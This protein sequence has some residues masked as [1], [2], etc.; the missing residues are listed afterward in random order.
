MSTNQF[1]HFSSFFF[2]SSQHLNVDPQTSALLRVTVTLMDVSTS[3]LQ[4]LNVLHYRCYSS[5]LI[6][7]HPP[8]IPAPSLCPLTAQSS[9]QTVPPIKSPFSGVTVPLCLIA[10]ASFV[11]VLWLSH[12]LILV[13]INPPPPPPPGSSR[14]LLTLSSLLSLLRPV[15]LWISVHPGEPADSM[16]TSTRL[17]SLASAANRRGC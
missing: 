13:A 5:P 1:L 12:F 3:D 7:H 6:L 16:D 14:P 11:P 9:H 8:F 2:E 10:L 4:A 15:H 17:T